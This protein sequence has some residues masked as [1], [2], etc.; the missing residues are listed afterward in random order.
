MWANF[1]FSCHVATFLVLNMLQ[2]LEVPG[3]AQRMAS[4]MCVGTDLSSGLEN[5]VSQ[6]D[7]DNLSVDEIL[8]NEI[9][10]SKE[11]GKDST[12]WLELEELGIDDDMLLSLDLSSKFPVCL[13]FSLD[14]S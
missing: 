1:F 8:A 2:L 4:L 3:L 13:Y 7:N 11:R 14:K 5:G 9:N 6:Q 10:Y 12:S